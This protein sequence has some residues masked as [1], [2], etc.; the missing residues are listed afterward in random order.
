MPFKPFEQIDSLNLLIRIRGRE[1]SHEDREDWFSPLQIARGKDAAAEGE[2]VGD[3]GFGV[4]V[5]VLLVGERD[6]ALAW[7]HGGSE[8]DYCDLEEEEGLGWSS[9]MD[10]WMWRGCYAYMFED[11]AS[12]RRQISSCMWHVSL[13]EL[14]VHLVPHI[15]ELRLQ[16]RHAGLPSSI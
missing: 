11:G 15:E 5:D 6:E 13:Q 8:V 3:A 4:E 2:D 14:W 10:R 9:V 7:E 12:A 1:A 16:R